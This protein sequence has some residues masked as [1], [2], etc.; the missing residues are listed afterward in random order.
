LIDWIYK[1]NPDKSLRVVIEWKFNCLFSRRTGYADLDERL[2]ST[3]T[4]RDGLLQLP[5]YPF[6]PIHN[7]GAEIAIREGVIKRKISYGTRSELG[8]SMGEH[9]LYNGYMPRAGS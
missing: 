9:V 4:N 8:K 3:D 2:A 7:N 6:I 1:N 5:D